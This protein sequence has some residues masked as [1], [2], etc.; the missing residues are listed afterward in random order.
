MEI[1]IEDEIQKEKIARKL[2]FL[3]NDLFV[4][5]LFEIVY[6]IALTYSDNNI[7]WS[8]VIKPQTV[9]SI[10]FY[11]FI[12][13][14][15]VTSSFIFN[16]KNDSRFIAFSPLFLFQSGSFLGY[17][18]HFLQSIIWFWKK[19]NETDFPMVRRMKVI[20]NILFVLVIAYL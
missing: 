16:V 5:V 2:E 12:F 6:F 15:M 11:N 17:I 8:K 13:L 4:F 3:R 1:E 20:S 10:L 9:L 19:E 18:S 7:D 14:K